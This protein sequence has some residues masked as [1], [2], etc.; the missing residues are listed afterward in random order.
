MAALY[1]YLA[2]NA[3]ELIAFPHTARPFIGSDR[4][5]VDHAAFALTR[6][7]D[8]M[9]ALIAE[10]TVCV[11]EVLIEH[12]RKAERLAF[13]LLTA[14]PECLDSDDV[15]RLVGFTS[16]RGNRPP[17]SFPLRTGPGKQETR[18]WPFRVQGPRPGPTVD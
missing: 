17:G 16:Y 11:T 4:G 10:A 7:L 2:G 8:A 15:R 9:E 1:V 14:R 3:A 18:A 12:W 5:H 13:A 6:D